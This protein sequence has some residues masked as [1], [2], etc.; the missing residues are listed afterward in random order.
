[1]TDASTGQGSSFGHWDVEHGLPV[2]RETVHPEAETCAWDPVGTPVTHRHWCAVGNRRFQ[3]VADNLGTTA[4]WDTAERFR[5]LTAA[6]PGT[7][8]TVVTRADGTSWATDAG[9]WPVPWFG[10]GAPVRTWG[11]TWFSVAGEHDG[12]Q[13]ERTVAC[14]EGDLPWLLVRVV[15]IAEAACELSI[16][17]EWHLSGSDLVLTA[18]DGPDSSSARVDSD[19]EEQPTARLV[20]RLELRPGVP[21]ICWFLLGLPDEQPPPEDPGGCWEDSL[22]ALRE[23]LPTAECDR[24]PQLS[25]EVPW[26]GALLTGGACSDAVLGEH[27]L[28]Q[29]SAYSFHMAFNGAARDPL[30]H[31]LPLV[32]S[33][34]DL[35]LSVLRNTCSWGSPDGELPWALD[36]DKQPLTDWFQPSDQALWA[37]WLAFEYAAATGDLAAF[38]RPLAFH[39]TYAAEPAPL[40]EHLVRQFRH[41]VDV[42]GVGATGHIRILNADWNDS[43]LRLSGVDRSLMQEQGESVLNSA[44]AAWVLP[45]FAGLLRRL[46]DPSLVAV[47]DEADT[48][49]DRWH[50]LVAGEW[51]GRW[52]RRA[53][54]P[55]AVVGDDDLWLEV[56]PWA[57]L[58]GAADD[59]RAREL[60]ATI[61]QT[62]RQGSPLGARLRG[63][64]PIALPDGHLA[65]EGTSGGV[66]FSINMTL[67]W[68]AAS[69]GPELAWDELGR[70]TLSAHTAAYPSVWEGTISG[71]D[72][73]NTPESPR[74]GHTWAW[75]SRGLGMQTFPVNNLHAHA[76]V[77]FTYLRLLGVEPAVDG[78]LRVGAGGGAYSS[79]VLELAPDGHGTVRTAGPVRIVTPTA[80]VEG[81][82][83]VTW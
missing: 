62:V 69:L 39:P 52:Y 24:L 79:R 68:A 81:T 61:D 15:V 20:R 63:P 17:E 21:S 73:Y 43:A 77:V 35:A 60:L 78:S 65:G 1:M 6:E 48:L 53:Y 51:N 23:R 67:A 19:G 71:P 58:C 49:A 9:R 56:Q 75:P 55:G 36:A 74:P 14:P 29:A 27:T 54:G 42:V 5:W 25:R 83:H 38:R 72:A 33:E 12:L 50:D 37:M 66:W 76:Q 32:Y 40:V 80:V 59:D 70:M 41:L 8:A 7:G 82:G 30:Q 3:L 16:A 28:D 34:P 31:A 45:R 26:H 11:P 64:V 4:V 44:M 22:V 18:A 57:I 2:F 13:V 10:S 46:D 47:A